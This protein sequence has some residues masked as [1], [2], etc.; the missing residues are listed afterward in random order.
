MF[1]KAVALAMMGFGLMMVVSAVLEARV[2]VMQR[3]ATATVVRHVAARGS[4]TRTEATH[5]QGR[6]IEQK[7]VTEGYV[8]MAPVLRYEVD[9]RA[10]ELQG[11]VLGVDSPY[12][13][14]ARVEIVYDP[15]RP[16]R[17]VVKDEANGWGGVLGGAAFGAI[18]AILGFVGMLAAGGWRRYFPSFR[19]T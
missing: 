16:Q 3:P 2:V 6:G 18:L 13:I 4:T 7:M 8:G 5:V 10:L 15:W 17:A 1:G 9:G 11:Q 14:G 12:P 19:L